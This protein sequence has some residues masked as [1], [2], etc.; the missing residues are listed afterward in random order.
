MYKL[1]ISD[2]DGTLVNNKKEITHY[3]KR[4]I[5]EVQKK[6]VEFIIATGRGY[7]GAKRVADVLK[8][9]NEI[10]C[11]NGSTIYDSNGELIFQRII[12]KNIVKKI[13]MRV[14]E[15]SSIFFASYGND[16]YISKGKIDASRPFLL[17]PPDNATE[18]SPENIEN[19][20]FEKIVILDRDNNLLNTYLRELKDETNIKSFISQENFLDIVHFESSKGIALKYLANLKNIE[21]KHILAFGDAF[22][23]YEMLKFAGKGVVLAN[24]FDELKEE[25]ESFDLTNDE[26]GVAEY[27]SKVFHIEI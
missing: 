26:N 24:G 20:D 27:I 7:R 2:L 25:F 13:F 19:F 17:I 16:I 15:T 1:I 22:N 14:L 8:L 5:E 6:G 23:D 12:D 21:L 3:T 18:L 9:E 4:V 11:N 10:I